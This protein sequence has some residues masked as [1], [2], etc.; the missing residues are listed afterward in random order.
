MLHDGRVTPNAPHTL[1]RG[2]TATCVAP[3]TEE[4]GGEAEVVEYA[5]RPG[6]GYAVRRPT[7]GRWTGSAGTPARTDAVLTDHGSVQAPERTAGGGLSFAEVVPNHV[8][9]R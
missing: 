2:S 4:A 1:F 8:S 6:W 7:Q 5:E 3:H 9:G